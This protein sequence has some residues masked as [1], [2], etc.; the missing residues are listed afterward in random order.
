MGW[1][2]GLGIRKG[3]VFPIAVAR[4][5]QIKIPIKRRQDSEPP[6]ALGL[7]LCQQG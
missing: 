3:R 5:N 7:G 2:A 4:Y 6:T 1:S